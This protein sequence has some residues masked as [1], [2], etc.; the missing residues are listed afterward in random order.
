MSKERKRTE[1]VNFCKVPDRKYVQLCG[2]Y[3]LFHNFQT[4]LL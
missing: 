1:S 2:S 4:L 3:T